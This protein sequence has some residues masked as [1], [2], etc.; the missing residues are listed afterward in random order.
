MR[1][2]A[3]DKIARKR[4]TMNAPE[5]LSKKGFVTTTTEALIYGFIQFQNTVRKT[6]TLS[7][8]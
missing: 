2:G 7:R 4:V 5:S 6:N 8:R 3:P 1:M